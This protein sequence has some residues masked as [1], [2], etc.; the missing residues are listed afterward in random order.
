MFTNSASVVSGF[1]SRA[2]LWLGNACMEHTRHTGNP[3]LHLVYF[4]EAYI[5]SFRFRSMI[6]VLYTRNVSHDSDSGAFLPKKCEMLI[7]LRKKRKNIWQA[8][9]NPQQ[10]PAPRVRAAEGEP[11]GGRGS[12]RRP[13]RC[14]CRHGPQPVRRWPLQGQGAI[15]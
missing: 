15:G 3:D 5:S 13:P 11:G 8:G 4:E 7:A 14:R 1:G 12:G 6:I 2:A 10:A 9:S